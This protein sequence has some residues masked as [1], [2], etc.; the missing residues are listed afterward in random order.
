MASSDDLA[1][2]S[3]SALGTA[4]TAAESSPDTPPVQAQHNNDADLHGASGG[5]G[6]E[7]LA[8]LV[9][10]TVTRGFDGVSGKVSMLVPG[11]DVVM[12]E[13]EDGDCED[14]HVADMQRQ[15]LL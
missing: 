15:G 4:Q 1:S 3:S 9:G 11:S 2:T 8:A 12:V 13:W 10:M 7:Q 5:V 14:M 6:A